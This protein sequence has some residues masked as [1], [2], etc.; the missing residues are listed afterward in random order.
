M[1]STEWGSIMFTDP[2]TGTTTT[3][4]VNAEEIGGGV[5]FTL[6]VEGNNPLIS[7]GDLLGFF[8]DFE[9]EDNEPTTTLNLSGNA[10]A[11]R[12]G[13]DNIL[14]AGTKANNM[15]GTAANAED[16]ATS[17]DA[18]DVG[19]QLTS[20]GAS[21]GNSDSRTFSISGISL[22]QLDGQR[23]GIR[24]QNTL[25][26]EGSLK[27]EGIFERPDPLTF[28][29]LSHGYWKKHGP[30]SAENPGGGLFNDWDNTSRDPIIGESKPVYI[31][32]TATS[33]E[34]FFNVNI[35]WGIQ[36]E[37]MP[38]DITLQQALEWTKGG[39]YALAREA[40]AAVLNSRDENIQYYKYSE[41][42]I[43]Q[44]TEM[45]FE[46]G[47]PDVDGIN[48]PDWA[49]NTEA[50]TGLKNLFEAQNTLELQTTI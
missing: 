45:V 13:D 44:W 17:N 36:G 9:G 29:G 42:D 37:G 22:D 26:A 30:S 4:K 46:G 11:L 21:D 50:I 32:N 6:S 3:V 5:T 2:E 34:A 48:G 8:I 15:N 1:A 12:Q 31:G 41:S 40:T 7:A 19:V 27:L 14:W 39:L 35:T 10:I 23:F 24:L 38:D 49:S 33:F 16:N 18:Y 25:N 20:A 47:I 28:Q 43:V